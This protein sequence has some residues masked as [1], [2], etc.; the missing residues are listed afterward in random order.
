MGMISGKCKVM[1]NFLAC[2]SKILIFNKNFLSTAKKVTE[3]FHC[4]L[5]T[6]H[7]RSAQL[8][9]SAIALSFASTPSY[10]A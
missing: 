1:E 6:F 4:L 2:G 10:C 8:N 9:F 5:Y 7:L 3:T